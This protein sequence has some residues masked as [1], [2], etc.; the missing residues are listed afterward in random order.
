[1]VGRNI[2]IKLFPNIVNAVAVQV[3]AFFLSCIK[4]ATYGKENTARPAGD[5]GGY[6]S[7]KAKTKRRQFHKS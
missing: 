4:L 6:T 2:E 1:M 3:A 7:Y 5:I